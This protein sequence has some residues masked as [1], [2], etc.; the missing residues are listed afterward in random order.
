MVVHSKTQER[1]LYGRFLSDG[2]SSEKCIYI[3]SSFIQHLGIALSIVPGNESPS[4]THPLRTWSNF[5]ERSGER[6]IKAL[7]VMPSSKTIA[8]YPFNHRW[9]ASA[10]RR[11]LAKLRRRL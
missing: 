6:N 11:Q 2:S 10:D 4:C 1:F 5:M 7:I 8:G 3:I 9:S